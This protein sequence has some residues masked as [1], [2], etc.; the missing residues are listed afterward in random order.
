[1][2]RKIIKPENCIFAFG[3]PTS[4][5]DFYNDLQRE[6]KDF[7]KS[8]EMKCK[9]AGKDPWEKYNKDII[10][11]IRKVEPMMK[12][13]GVT[14]IHQLTLKDFGEILQSNRF[15]VVIL[16]THLKEE[17]NCACFTKKGYMA[18]LAKHPDFLEDIVHSCEVLE[19]LGKNQTNFSSLATTVLSGQRKLGKTPLVEIKNG[20]VHVK[21]DDIVYYH[22]KEMKLETFLELLKCTNTSKIEFYDGL[23]DLYEITMQIPA[24]FNRFIDLN[25]CMPEDFTTVLRKCRPHC[26]VKYKFDIPDPTGSKG[27]IPR[28]VLYFYMT[29]FIHMKRKELTY[30]QAIK[31]VL[32]EFLKQSKKMGGCLEKT[33]KNLQGLFEEDWQTGW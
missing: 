32:F 20:I 19:W 1:M 9:R 16:L 5:E 27:V 30:L 14:V 12:D 28:F 11:V 26:H 21:Y 10:H 17:P 15:D 7:A 25:I 3:I 18:F 8:V 2:L 29:L 4:K 6:N 33:K 13:L 31:E 23:K 24:D 22:L